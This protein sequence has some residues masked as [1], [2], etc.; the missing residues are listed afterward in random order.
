MQRPLGHKAYGS[1]PHLPGSRTGE[2]DRH[3]N[4]GVAKLCLTQAKSS[5]DRVIVQEKL[6][7]SCVAIART[8]SGIV[9]LGRGG[10]LA[11]RSPG[12]VR[13]SFA[14]WVEA[15]HAR[16][17]HALEPG[18]RLVG[19][20]LFIAHGTRYALPHEPFVAFDLMVNKARSPYAQLLE[21]AQ[22]AQLITPRLIHHGEPIGIEAVMERLDADTSAHG[23]LDPPEG[24]VW[25]IERPD[26]HQGVRVDIVAKYVRP[27]KQDSCFLPEVTGEDWCFNAWPQ[28]QGPT[29]QDLLK[30]CQ[31]V[32]W[33]HE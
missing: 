18:E 9:A 19:E 26:R 28:G 3:V 27:Q 5:K 6:D 21:R 2:A 1:I 23:A 30:S 32:R 22:R 16:F 4:E 29:Q 20:W 25:R 24:A 8:E 31:Q 11:S 7:G 12:L 13:R 10:D 14:A 15:Q 33:W 17:M